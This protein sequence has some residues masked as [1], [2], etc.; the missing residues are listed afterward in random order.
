[1]FRPL[2]GR[3][4]A[5]YREDGAVHLAGAIDP[6]WV[7]RIGRAVD[8]VLGEPSRLRIHHEFHDTDSGSGRFFEAEFLW[9]DDPDFRALVL[10]SPHAEIAAVAMGSTT[11]TFFYDQLFVKEPGT[12]APTRWHQDLSYWPVRG[13][14]IVTV[15]MPLDAVNR[16]NGAVAYVRGSHRW[17]DVFA[18]ANFTE[19]TADAM[20]R[21]KDAARAM[22][23]PVPDI[24]ADPSRYDIVSWDAEPG[25]VILHHPRTIHGAPGN[26]T[27]NR[28]RR[29]ITTRWL[30]DDTVYQP[31]SYSFI[32]GIRDRLPPFQAVIGQ[33]LAGA[34][35][36][37]VWPRSGAA[38]D[39]P[40]TFASPYCPPYRR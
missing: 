20:E 31:G 29:A 34:L 37:R 14:R 19:D 6:D 33:P 39:C 23:A 8:R 24:D 3:E 40:A 7:E 10:D 28:R 12:T 18:P 30:G 21:R 16:D 15:W 38:I 2:S 9:L 32:D 25:D 5:A 1:M 35:F 22:D 11:A 13:E 4:V 17:A 26:R 36:P 27:T